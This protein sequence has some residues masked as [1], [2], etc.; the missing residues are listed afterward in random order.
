[1][2]RASLKSDIATALPNG[3]GN[4]AAE[5][6]AAF[7]SVIDAM[8][9]PGDDVIPLAQFVFNGGGLVLTAASKVQTGKFPFAATITGWQLLG[10]QSGSAVFDIRL[11]QPAD[12][13]MTGGDSIA[14]SEKPTLSGAIYAEDTT[15]STWTTAIAAGDMLEAYLES[16]TS[17]TRATIVLLGKR[18]V[19]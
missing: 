9:V 12:L 11:E 18:T 15:L 13:P 14:G 10:D 2:T 4:T 7:D 6:R 3:G 8:A 1:M 17:L 5:V 16:V 19:P